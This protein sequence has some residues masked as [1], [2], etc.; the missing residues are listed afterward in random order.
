MEEEAVAPEGAEA[1]ATPANE[2]EKV[3]EAADPVEPE[4]VEPEEVDSE[5]EPEP[6]EPEEIEFDFGGNKFRVAKDALP[7]ELAEQ[8]QKFGSDIYSDYTRKTQEIAETRKSL[9]AQEASIQKLSALNED[10]LN[11]YSEGARI[12]SELEHLSKIDIDWKSNPD[13]ARQVSD[14]I[15]QR[16]AQ[17][18]RVVQELGSKE[19]E[20]TQAQEAEASRRR[21]QGRAVVEKRIPGFTEKVSEVIDYVSK[22][23]D[24]PRDAAER[25]WPLNFRS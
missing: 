6:E 4:A 18:D 22:T 8:V 9:E 2:P 14:A 17:L 13:Q 20:L 19:S 12:K 15:S 16:R 3:A 23:Y 7:P 5:A 1:E 25:D 11:T 10:V 21:E 24:I